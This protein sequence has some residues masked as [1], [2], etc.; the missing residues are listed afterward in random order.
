MSAQK[1]LQQ[2]NFDE[3]FWKIDSLIEMVELVKQAFIISKDNFKNKKHFFRILD[4]QG[5]LRIALNTVRDTFMKLKNKPHNMKL[6]CTD[7]FI[8]LDL[9]EIRIVAQFKI[10]Q[11]TNVNCFTPKDVD[12]KGVGKA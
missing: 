8:A 7:A 2:T 4:K 12:P 5:M 1:Q 10:F 9:L 11:E 3:V 6:Q